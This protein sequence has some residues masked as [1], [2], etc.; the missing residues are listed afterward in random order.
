VIFGG[1]F[2]FVVVLYFVMLFFVGL[3]VCVV[4]FVSCGFLVVFGFVLFCFWCYFGFGYVVF[5]VVVGVCFVLCMF[6]LCV[7]VYIGFWCIVY[8]VAICLIRD[9]L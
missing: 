4:R 3:C 9:L 6:V 5:W 1:L 8:N 7:R 2:G